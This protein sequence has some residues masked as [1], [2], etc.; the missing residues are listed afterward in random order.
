MENTLNTRLLL[1]L[2]AILGTG[3][4]IEH[5][6]AVASDG[7]SQRSDQ[8]A[9]S[10]PGLVIENDGEL[11]ETYPRANYEVRFRAHGGV[12]VLHWTLEKGALPPGIKLEDD[13]LLHGEPQ[14]TGEFQF[15]VSVRDGSQQAVQKGFL[16]RV[17]SALSL[18]WKTAAHVD[19][20]RIEGSVEV[21][22]TT[23]DDMDLTFIVMAVPGNGRATAIGYQHFL[24]RRGTI[25]KE[26]PFG[27]KLPRGGYMVHVDA[28]GEVAAKNLIYRD[29]MQTPKALQVMVGP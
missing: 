23:A 1:T 22:N 24:L 3:C 16:L 9:Q 15:I 5:V 7:L 28:V 17:L 21:T 10:E 29:R 25:A 11:P 4:Q 8:A 20:N 26:L 19:G 13:G 14:R 18:N 12:P 27:E 2:L 6:A